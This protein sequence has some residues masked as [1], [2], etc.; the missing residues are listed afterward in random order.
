MLK[1]FNLYM[2]IILISMLA[3]FAHVSIADPLINDLDGSFIHGETIG[4]IGTGFGTK[5]PAAPLWWDN[6]EG[7][8]DNPSVL[9]TAPISQVVSYLSSSERR[10]TETRPAP[11]EVSSTFRTQYRSSW[12]GVPQPHQNSNTYI[13]GGHQGST[14]APVVM[15]AVSPRELR[16]KFFI[17]WYLRLGD[18]WQDVPWQSDSNYKEL[19]IEDG[20]DSWATASND[21]AYY[22][23]GDNT[24]YNSSDSMMNLEGL[25]GRDT[26]NYHVPVRQWVHREVILDVDN[27][28]HSYVSRNGSTVIDHHCSGCSTGEDSKGVVSIGAYSVYDNSPQA[29][30][31]RMKR[32]FDDIYVDITMSRVVVGN[33]IRYSDCTIMEPQIPSAWSSGAI[34]VSVNAGALEPCEKAYLFVIDANNVVSD[35]DLGSSGAQGFPVRLVTGSGEQPCLPEKRDSDSSIVQ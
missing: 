32:Y 13:A 23:T 10:Y 25:H 22:S 1:S 20:G 5:N 27:D 7:T 24:P 19:W 14:N 16:T 21:V 34:T 17:M 4:I 12:D 15:V 18:D 35:Q 26:N 9:L 28:F 31:D 29:T 11:V 33:R 30:D 8:V 3:I 2:N 6:C